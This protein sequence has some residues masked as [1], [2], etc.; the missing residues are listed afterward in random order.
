MLKIE[1]DKDLN[2]VTLKPT[3]A[4]SASDFADLTRQVDEYIGER[5]KAPNLMIVADSFPYWDSLKAIGAHVKFVR[6]HHK[7]V[8]KV[9]IVGDGFV[10][11]VMP[12]IGD[13]FVAA[14]IKHFAS[15]Q[16]DEAR[17]WAT[18]PDS[19]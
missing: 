7:L 4:L 2:L 13:L 1:I 11:N 10:M 8:S 9:A 19:R 18:S 14:T 16:L 6:D 12:S 15:G 17:S 5:D 3:G